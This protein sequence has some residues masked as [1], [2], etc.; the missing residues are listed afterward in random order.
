MS[1]FVGPFPDTTCT[2][3][4]ERLIRVDADD[5]RHPW[6]DQSA[7]DIVDDLVVRALLTLGASGVGAA[8]VD[9]SAEEGAAL[10]LGRLWG[11]R[12]GVAVLRRGAE[13]LSF[14]WPAEWA[15]A[16]AA[17]AEGACEALPGEVAS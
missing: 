5:S 6:C 11:R 9:G 12:P 10:E 17:Y 3:C 14:V 16:V 13:E 4:D 7:L 15:P 2:V 8:V 1:T